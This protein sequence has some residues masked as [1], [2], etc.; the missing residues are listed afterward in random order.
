MFGDDDGD[1]LISGIDVDVG[2]P[3]SI[4][5]SSLSLIGVVVALLDGCWMLILLTSTGPPKKLSKGIVFCLS[6]LACLLWKK[7]GFE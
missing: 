3:A 6:V 2:A 4:H 7:E 5:S 1:S